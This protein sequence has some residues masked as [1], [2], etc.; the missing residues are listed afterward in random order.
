MKH[1]LFG[2]NRFDEKAVIAFLLLFGIAEALLGAYKNSKRNW[3]DY[4]AEIVSFSQL[5]ILVQPAILLL[6]A[7]VGRSFF[8]AAEGKFAGIGGGYQFLILL[9][10]E[11]MPQYWWHRLSHHSPFLWKFHLA[12][13]ASPGMGVGVAFRN[14][15]LY[16]LFMP[17]IW[18]AATAVFLGFGKVYVLYTVI[19]LLIVIGAHS[20]LRWDSF[21][22][23]YKLLHPLAWLLEHTISTPATHFGHHGLTNADGIS[24]NNGN[25]GN[26]LFI[27]DQLFGTAKFT[28]NYPPE[29]GVEHDPK[30][31]WYVLLYYPFVR[32]GKSDSQL[33]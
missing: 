10:I 5:T 19:K 21:L 17:N 20:E 8:P 24:N 2:I 31:P 15:V 28:R 16:Y 26:M 18:L 9:L 11:D 7:F 14:N 25:F 13:H 1:E 12:H 30:D 23:R 6:V 27:W 3:N 32:S 33:K 29:F 22:Y 4:L